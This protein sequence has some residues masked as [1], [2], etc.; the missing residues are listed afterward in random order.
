MRHFFEILSTDINIVQYCSQICNIIWTYTR[1]IF[2]YTRCRLMV[3][4]VSPWGITVNLKWV[5]GKSKSRVE[6]AVAGLPCGCNVTWKNSN[7]KF[8]V[9][10]KPFSVCHFVYD[11][12]DGTDEVTDRGCSIAPAPEVQDNS[13]SVRVGAKRITA[14]LSWLRRYQ[15]SC[16]AFRRR[17]CGMVNWGF[18]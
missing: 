16:L 1:E 12:R 15:I 13:D 18:G 14:C 6:N 4:F 2:H 9:V 7:F 8:N 11:I 10:D 3:L 17:R 5:C